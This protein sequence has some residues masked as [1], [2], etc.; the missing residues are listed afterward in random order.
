MKKARVQSCLIF[1]FFSLVAF[2]QS[3]SLEIRIKNQPESK[4]VLGTLSGEVF[5]A[6]DSVEYSRLFMQNEKGV[7]VAKFNMPADF[8]TGMYR[9]VFG[10]TT[11][12]KVMGESPQQLDFIFNAKN[13]V[14]ETD[15]K[16]PADSLIVIQ[17]EENRVWF[18][19]LKK[20]KEYRKKL[21]LLED[22]VDYLQ[23]QYG[24]AKESGESS[25]AIN[26]IEAKMAQRANAFNQL[27]MEKNS[28]IEQAV[29]AN[30]T[31]FASRLIGLYREPFR[32]GFLSRHERLEYFQRGYFRFFDFSDQS[33]INSNVITDKIFEYL[34]TY[35]NKNFTNEQREIA[36]IKAVDV[37][38]NSVKKSVND[39][40]AN[41]V[42]RFV[43]NYLITGFERL[44]MKG[45]LVHIS[46]KY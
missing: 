12:A 9:L 26:G 34:V 22:E 1:L 36:Y 29:E 35:N 30:N 31:L 18:G 37:I 4:I 45:V 24:K 38:M 20:E 40:T 7:K 44:E 6:V 23:M 19:F 14:F 25:S 46:E 5:T 21:N 32:D 8:H 28:F 27:Q 2:P 10:Q 33:L 42:Y 3:Y 41:P 13:I 16:A 11:Y 43:L 15:F 17:S 39:N